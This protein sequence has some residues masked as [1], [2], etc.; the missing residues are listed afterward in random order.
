MHNDITGK[1][2]AVGDRIVYSGGGYMDLH[3]G[4]VVG[5]TPKRIK[6]SYRRDDPHGTV[7]TSQ[8]V[9]KVD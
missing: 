5:F 4:Y 6:V 2:L 8:Q 3:V 1:S 7:K 9:A